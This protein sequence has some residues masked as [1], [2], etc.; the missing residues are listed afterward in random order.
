MIGEAIRFILIV[1]ALATPAALAVG[2]V[3]GS[4]ALMARIGW[5]K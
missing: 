3:F 1:G 4:V 2:M 5:I